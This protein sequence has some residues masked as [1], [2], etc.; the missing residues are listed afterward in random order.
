MT[1]NLAV[2][3]SDVVLHAPNVHT[4]GGVALLNAVLAAWPGRRPLR[5]FLDIR[6]KKQ[7]ILPASAE[8]TWVA[9]SVVDRLRAEVLAGRAADRVGATLL[10]FHGLPPLVSIRGKVVIFMQNRLLLEK[11]SLAEYP[12]RVRLRIRIERLWCRILQGRCTRYVV[13]TPSMAT[14]LRR[15][16]DQDTHVSVIP[17]SSI[18]SLESMKSPVAPAKKFDFVY[19]ASGEAHKNHRILLDAWRIL[20]DEGLTPSLALTVNAAVHPALSDEI[21]RHAND[22][23]VNISNLGHV[24]P[25]EIT[26]LYTCSTALIFPSRLESLG[27]PLIEANLLGLP[28]LASELDYVRDVV[29]PV[30]TFDPTSPLSIARAVRRFLKAPKPIV[31]LRTAEEF[32]LEALK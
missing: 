18:P 32:L 16:L 28:I 25:A 11:S 2:Q 26:Q 4:G 6:A 31:K 14:L 24:S 30:E 5:A 13:Q 27:L 9:P 17:F 23:G 10:C 12:G 21:N 15:W 19:V 20:A 29:D 22:G 1:E 8:I 3:L 7:L